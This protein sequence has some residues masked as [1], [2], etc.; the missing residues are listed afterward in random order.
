MNNMTPELCVS[1]DW[2]CPEMSNFTDIIEIRI[3]LRTVFLNNWLRIILFSETGKPV[4]LF[5]L[6]HLSLKCLFNLPKN[7]GV[8]RT[9]VTLIPKTYVSTKIAV[10]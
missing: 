6:S 2:N 3:K 5:G 7:I 9:S 1:T 4:S 10:T 8:L